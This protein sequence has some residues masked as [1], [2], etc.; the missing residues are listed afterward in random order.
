MRIHLWNPVHFECWDWRNSIERGIGGSETAA[1]ELAWRLG[2]RGHD[3]TVYAPLPDDS[4]GS[5]RDTAWVRLEDA[6]FTEPGLWIF[7][8]DVTCLDNLPKTADQTVWLMCEDE[9]PRGVTAER[10]LKIDRVLA[11]CDWHRGHLEKTCPLTKD[12][13]HVSANGIKTDRLRAILAGDRPERNP[14]RLMYASSPDRA[15]LPLL[16]M[17]RRA[18]EFV[19]DLELHCFYGLDNIQKLIELGPQFAHY[20]RLIRELEPALD[21]PGVTW[22]G[23]VS[24][25]DLYREWL[26]TGLWCYPCSGFGESSCI[27]AMESQALGAIPIVSPH[28]ALGDNVMFGFFIEGDARRDALVQ[29]RFVSAI[30]QAT[31]FPQRQ[32]VLRPEMMARALK[33]FDWERVVDQ[34]Q[35]WIE[36]PESLNHG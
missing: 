16:K 7:F 20:K 36:R 11:L 6:D 12:V 31:T 5:W 18:R 32:D 24:Q 2:R 29:A 34:W 27:T 1:T 10:M 23:R 17:F 25:T 35:N 28:A 15:L 21:Q 13:L 9:S 30:V 8:R 19:A 26:K 3:V 14:R 4:S 33:R 22:H